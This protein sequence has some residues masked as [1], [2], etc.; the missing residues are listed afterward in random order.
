MN[1]NCF[2]DDMVSIDFDSY[3]NT[4]TGNICD[5][6]KHFH[7]CTS[8]QTTFKKIYNEMG[9]TQA[10]IFAKLEDQFLGIEFDIMNSYHVNDGQVN[11]HQFLLL[12]MI[13]LSITIKNIFHFLGAGHFDYHEVH[14][15]QAR[16]PSGKHA[17]SHL[18]RLPIN[19][20]C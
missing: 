9:L 13:N 3:V 2:S 20:I 10:I 12:A 11:N 16:N 7:I 18:M 8:S 5:L 19:C 17:P 6:T 15:N 1:N 4:Q 14:I